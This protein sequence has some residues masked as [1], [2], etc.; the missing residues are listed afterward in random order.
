[1]HVSSS[2]DSNSKLI[3][4]EIAYFYLHIM[5]ILQEDKHR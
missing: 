1:M 5:L 3:I 2:L 4:T